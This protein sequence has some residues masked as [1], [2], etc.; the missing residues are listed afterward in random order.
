MTA[1]Y[2]RQSVDRADSVSIESQIEH[3]NYEVKKEEHQIYIDKGFSGKNTERPEFQ[4]MM[5]HIKQ[6]IIKKVIVYKLDRISRSILDFSNMME[7]FAKY[8]VEFVSTTE[9]F[10]TSTPMG[11]A[12]LNIC[13]VFAQLERE[14]IQKRVKDAYES[15]SKMGFYMGGRVPYGFTKTSAA[16]NGINTSQYIPVDDEI[17]HLQIIFERYSKSATTLSEIVRYLKDNNIQKAH[18]AE[19]STSRISKVL[20][21]PIYA[22]A[23]MDLY[24]F[25]ASRNTE[26]VNPPENFIGENGCYMYTKD[27]KKIINS[28]KNMAQYENMVL[29]LAPHN[30]IVD[31]EIWIKCR[32]KAEQN[33]Q[34]PNA[35]KTRKTWLSGKLK[36]AKCGY[37][38]RYN[39]W[40][41]KTV[42]NE[43]FLCS[44][45][46]G[47][48]RCDGIGAVK[49]KFIESEI[50]K[51]IEEK[52]K[53]IKIEQTKPDKNLAETN[54]IKTV[55]ANKE[56]EI[57][58]ILEKLQ[59]A[60]D[61]VLKYINKTV[62]KLDNEITELKNELLK[63]EIA[64]SSKAQI[65]V[66]KIDEVFKSW[67]KVSSDNQQA[68][69]DV[70][71]NKV[72]ITKETI[73][74]DW[75]I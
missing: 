36:C 50:L 56:N 25:Y 47:N 40:V 22:K 59:D 26:I 42:E 23:D 52:I 37:A 43:Y 35:R 46:S 57:H 2:A 73:E 49:K 68:L 61:G 55:I 3:C 62:E 41:G 12:M 14:T 20:R 58:E 66:G 71:I 34:I 39:K 44:E 18:G 60:N 1:I 48:R 54:A 72:L 64:K 11:R 9:K 13:I 67:D 17:K 5:N 30:G 7:M 33:V 15:R 6:G 51:Q 27:V 74:I 10:D 38:L 21:N 24:N 53:E 75:K 63:H 16:I 8:D 45:A 70:L 69:A 31:S 32:L 4:L 19:W 65:D 29:V 28:K